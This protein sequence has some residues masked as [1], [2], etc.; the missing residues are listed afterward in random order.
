MVSG[1]NLVIRLGPLGGPP[2]RDRPMVAQTIQALAQLLDDGAPEACRTASGMVQNPLK[3]DFIGI[4]YHIGYYIG[5]IYHIGY[6]LKA[7]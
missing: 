6:L 1:F 2:L 5:L 7:C 4:I 3:R